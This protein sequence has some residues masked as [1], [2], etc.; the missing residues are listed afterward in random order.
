MADFCSVVIAPN[1]HKFCGLISLHRNTE[2]STL[3][4]RSVSI[5]LTSDLVS[6]ANAK[7]LKAIAEVTTIATVKV[8]VRRSPVTTSSKVNLVFIL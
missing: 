8:N 3:W 2:I 4:Y 7:R 1:S 5:I 6:N